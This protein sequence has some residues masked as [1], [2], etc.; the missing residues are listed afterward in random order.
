MAA[1]VTDLTDLPF[2]PRLLSRDQAARYVGVSATQFTKEVAA[3]RWPAPERR[4][5]GGNRS[6]RLLWDRALLDR[7]QDEYSGIV[8]NSPQSTL[9]TGDEWAGWN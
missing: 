7:R 1:K 2:W 4:G 8:Q 9:A 5:Q 6:G 3:G